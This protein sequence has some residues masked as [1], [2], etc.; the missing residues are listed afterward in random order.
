MCCLVLVTSKPAL[1][2]S[3]GGT[4]LPFNLS[5]SHVGFFP[6]AQPDHPVNRDTLATQKHDS[7]AHSGRAGQEG[8]QEPRRRKLQERTHRQ[9]VV[10]PWG[11]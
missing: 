6:E 9:P 10:P 1:V 4:Y 5:C 3:Q 2:S 11:S 7:G 8:E